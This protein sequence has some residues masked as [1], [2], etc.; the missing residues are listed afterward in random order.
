MTLQEKYDSKLVDMSTAAK[1]FQSHDVIFSNPI[2]G[3][4]NEI[5]R[6][7]TYRYEEL[8]DIQLHSLFA[9]EPFDFMTKPEVS[10]KIQFTSM[11]MGPLERKLY[12]GGLFRINS[13]NFSDMATHIVTDVKPDWFIAQVSEIDEDGYF[14]TGPFGVC[15][16]R[17]IINASQKVMVQ[18]NKEVV[19]VNKKADKHVGANH[20]IHIDEVDIIVEHDEKLAGIPKGGEPTLEEKQI[21]E[22]IIPHIKDGSTLQIG[23]GGLSNAV[24]LGLVGNVKDLGVYTEMI[25]E[26]MIELTKQ[27]VITKP[28]IG[29]F[30]LGSQSLYEFTSQNDLVELKPLTVVNKP[31][32]ISSFENFVSI[33]ATLMVDLTG[34]VASEGIGARQVSSVGGAADFVKGATHSKGGQSF[35]CLTSTQTNP[36]TKEVTSNIRF[37][38]PPATPVTVARADVMN[39]VTEYGIANIFNLSIAERAEK[40][41]EIAHPDF[42]DELR[43]QAIDAKYI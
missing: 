40:L 4:P 11:F 31:S 17:E 23:F 27:K 26:S 39:I 25:T 2:T 1:K 32:N 37:N 10:Q 35:I 29:G 30:A 14:N 9:L 16:G 8:E 24:S 28:I 36:K 12:P 41:I 13:I 7:L 6:N 5:I 15:L 34:Q 38:L 19:P 22:H 43:Q 33:N 20:L 21:A 3:M 18:V 42:R